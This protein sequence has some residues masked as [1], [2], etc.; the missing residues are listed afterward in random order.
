MTEEKGMIEGNENDRKG[1]KKTEINILI[2]C[3]SSKINEILR[4]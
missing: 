2:K 1:A 3:V 4:P